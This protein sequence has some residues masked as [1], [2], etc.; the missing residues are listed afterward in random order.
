MI[1]YALICLLLGAMA[2]GQAPMSAPPTQKPGGPVGTSTPPPDAKDQEA[3]EAKVAPDAPVITIDGLCED[4]AAN[5]CK[6]VITKEQFEKM[7]DAIQPNM[8]ARARRQF[9]NRYSNALVM[10]AKA[11]ELGLDQGPKFEQRLQLA[12]TQILSQ[13][14]SQSIQ[15]KAAQISDQDIQDYF[16]KNKAD[17]EEA[18]LHRVFI[19]RVQQ[20][21]AS[22]VK[23]SA[24]EEAKQSAAGEKAMKTEAEKIRA[25]AAA[26]GDLNKLQA[27]AFLVAGIKTKSPTT[28]MGKVRRSSL[29][30]GQTS[31]MD[32]K[33][34]AVSELLSDQ[35]GYFVY[36]VGAKETPTLDSVK[37][38]IKGTLRSQRMQE[39]MQAVQKSATP[40]LDEAY[41][42][43]EAPQRP[44]PGMPGMPGMGQP[45]PP[46]HP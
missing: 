5:P 17:F 25:A 31:V 28:D 23:L 12:R 46:R 9:A 21:P 29:P 6:T 13:S 20:Q 10:S 37:E 27:E 26:G 4:K 40:A 15:E 45:V 3:A 16:D 39:Q 2:W 38:E 24:A 14:L 8:P 34:G 41:F 30:Q 22:K 44:M 35:S 36:K 1:R 33:T 18:T 11:H 42:G 32:L 43:P 19:P 7:V